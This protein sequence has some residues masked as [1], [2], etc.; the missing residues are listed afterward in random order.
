M[1]GGTGLARPL[2]TI[3]I[4]LGADHDGRNLG[5]ALGAVQLVDQARRLALCRC[6]GEHDKAGTIGLAERQCRIGIVERFSD[7]PAAERIG[8]AFEDFQ[9]GGA[10][11]DDDDQLRGHGR[12]P[13]LR[14]C[15]QF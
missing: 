15:R 12:T 10:V 8:E 14:L 5:A 4:L 9:V 7:G 11:I 2:E 13:G 1:V 6:G 3:E